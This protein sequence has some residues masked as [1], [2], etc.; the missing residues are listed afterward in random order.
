MRRDL[1]VSCREHIEAARN[2][3]TASGR[4]S[5][6]PRPRRWSRD[7]PPCVPGPGPA[8]YNATGTSLSPRPRSRCWA[9][10][11]MCCSFPARR[12]CGT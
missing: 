7:W 10:G 5:S 2:S 9:C 12:R 1:A 4:P 11:L 6:A 8:L 3:P